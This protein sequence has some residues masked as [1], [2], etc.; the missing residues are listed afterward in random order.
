M[1]ALEPNTI[2]HQSQT[3]V[4]YGGGMFAFTMYPAVPYPQDHP[5][6][7]QSVQ[8]ET[9]KT[10]VLPPRQKRR[11]SVQAG[12][13][14]CIHVPSVSYK[15]GRC[16]SIGQCPWQWP[17]GPNTGTKLSYRPRL[18]EWWLNDFSVRITITIFSDNTNYWKR[19]MIAEG[20]TVC[21]KACICAVFYYLGVFWCRRCLCR[22]NQLLLTI[23][24]IGHVYWHVTGKRVP[25]MFIIRVS[26]SPFHRRMLN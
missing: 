22:R 13:N 12:T 7:V 20:R 9:T 8:K 24:Y 3:S 18:Y 11:T 1:M 14:W 15:E 17:E 4:L 10:L 21:L 25:Q 16:F 6:K 23:P 26:I 19:I 2:Y 5:L